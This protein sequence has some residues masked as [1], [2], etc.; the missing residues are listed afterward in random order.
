MRRRLHRTALLAV[1]LLAALAALVPAG[2]AGAAG[3]SG[4][5]RVPAP[6][7]SAECVR[8]LGVA[9]YS[10]RQLHRA[11]DLLPLYA[12][13]F[14]GRGRTIVIMDPFGSPTIRHDLAV[15]DRGTGLPAPPSFRILRPVG[16][17]PP[18][19]P[20]NP[21]M[22]DKAGETSLDVEWS[23]AI[24]PGA[25]I[26]LVETPGLTERNGGTGGGYRQL[27]A[28]ENYV[29]NRN[30]GDVIS[31]SFSLPEQNFP[32]GAIGRL[33]QAFVNAFRHRVSVLAASNDNGVSG[34]KPPLGEFF[35]RHRVVEWPASDPLVTAVG[36]TRLHLDAAGRRTSPDTAWNDTWDPAATSFFGRKPPYPL[37]SN[38]GMSRIFARPW[39]QYLVRGIVGERRG[40]P[41]VSMSASLSGGVLTYESFPVGR[42][43]RRVGWGIGAGTS[44]AT[45]EFAGVVA[46]ADQYAGHRLG[47]VNPA[48]YLLSA[49]RAPGIADVTRGGNTVSFPAPDGHIFRLRGYPARPG[50]DLVTGVGTV[51]AARLVPELAALGDEA[52]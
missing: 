15:F 16:R 36:G 11:Y 37:A 46:I 49:L 31:Q 18:Y 44:E 48:L 12:H 28:A 1:V 2:P 5:A 9:C 40:V 30:L 13:G 34:P 33:R 23:H 51:N 38:G 25:G 3:R 27:M 4:P 19:D 20:D 14:D 42:A 7:S 8:Q 10:P 43:G 45:P 41:D 39:Y 26:L 24:A 50:Y 29:I 6:P 35:Y 22:V 52:R 21:I 17:I 47:L 32:P